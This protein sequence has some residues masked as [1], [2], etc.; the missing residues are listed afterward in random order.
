LSE[1]DLWEKKGNIAYVFS[2]KNP[3]NKPSKYEGFFPCEMVT[4]TVRPSVEG[5]RSLFNLFYSAS[6]RK[7]LDKMLKELSVE[8]AHAHNI[9]GRLTT[10]VLDCLYKAGI[11][12]VMTLHDYKVICPNYKLMHHGKICEDCRDNEYYMAIL[13][14]C[15]KNSLIASSIYAF[16][17]Y[18]NYI[19]EKYTKNVGYFISP[20][21]FLKA[22]LV[23]F[24]WPESRIEF[25]PN[26]LSV[27]DFAPNYSPGSYFLYLGRLSSEKGIAT[28][29]NAFKLLMNDDALLRIVGEGPSEAELKKLARSDARISFT[30]YLSGAA[31]EEITKNALAI[32]VPSEWYENAPLSILEAMAYGKPVI[33]S[34]I[35]GIPE[36]ID[37]EHNGFLFEPGNVNELNQRLSSV[38]DMHKDDL[39]NMGFSARRKVEREYNAELHYSR[40]INLYQKA[41]SNF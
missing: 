27:S 31:L 29:I 17:T 2:R 1:I 35:G 3:K 8:V 38:F 40:L 7:N 21:R 30:G 14:R 4:D 39:I 9:Y 20:S 16:E 10:S 28:L 12:V 41:I 23:E 6:A 36:M 13:N 33:G 15:H 25:I 18:F 26:F 37:E 32:V 22:K 24:G 19:F 5:L 34:T 11:P